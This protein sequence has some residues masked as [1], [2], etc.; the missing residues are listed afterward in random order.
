MI[1]LFHKIYLN[2]SEYIQHGKP[3]LI[4]SSQ[5]NLNLSP[6]IKS[7]YLKDFKSSIKELI[8]PD[9]IYISYIHLFESLSTHK[10]GFIIYAD[11]QSFPRIFIA[12]FKTVLNKDCCHSIYKLYLS[13]LFKIEMLHI[14]S[15]AHHNLKMDNYR[16]S[17]D[18][19]QKLFSEIQIGTDR[20]KTDFLK[21]ESHGIGIEFLLASYLAERTY[22]ASLQK[23]IITLL[24]KDLEKYLYELKEIILVHPLH[25]PF[26]K[27]LN[28]NKSYDFFN[29]TEFV[30]EQ[31]SSISVFFDQKI[32]NCIG[33]AHASSTKNINF[34][35]ITPEDIKAL[36]SFSLVAGCTWSEESCYQF[37]KSDVNKLQF[38]EYIQN[39]TPEAID[40]MIEVEAE[41]INAA[42][43][44]FSIDL[45]T[46]NHYLIHSMLDEWNNG[47]TN[48][49][50]CYKLLSTDSMVNE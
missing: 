44:F 49:A 22:S 11:P 1:H 45:H 19:W 32:W 5:G 13:Y 14:P 28:L 31:N 24:R 3:C 35:N 21:K 43:A 12:W 9:R 30:H 25:K 47:S 16:L 26:I 8:G 40:R 23:S 33:M 37:T 7:D 15:E 48:L 46:V 50:S 20:Q 41:F 42:G 36:E 4:L 34:E 27:R 6:L 10:D 29:F 38:I 39:P 18:E 17:L 2:F